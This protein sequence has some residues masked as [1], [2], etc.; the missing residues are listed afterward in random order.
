[1][2]RLED[3]WGLLQV[4]W[5]TVHQSGDIDSISLFGDS[6]IHFQPLTYLPLGQ[7]RLNLT[8]GPGL[9]GFVGPPSP[10]SKSLILKKRNIEVSLETYNSE[11][12]LL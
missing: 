3:L 11:F 6:F 10:R 8:S 12:F 5:V 1:M 7:G 4:C 2:C 9:R